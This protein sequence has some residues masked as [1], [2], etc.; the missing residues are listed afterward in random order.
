MLDAIPLKDK[1]PLV[2]EYFSVL[3]MVHVSVRIDVAR[4]DLAVSIP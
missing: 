3:Y 2:E 1:F 4:A